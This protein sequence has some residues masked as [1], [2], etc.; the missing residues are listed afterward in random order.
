MFWWDRAADLLT[1]KGSRLKRFGLITTNSLKQEFSGRV[2]GQR[3]KAK[4]PISLLMAIPDHPWTKATRDAAAVRI[5]MTV[6][7]AGTHEG[8]LREVLKERDLDTDTPQIELVERR[9]P[10]NPDLTVG[11]DVT[12]AVALKANGHLCS[13][14]VKLHGSGFIV[15]REEAGLLG[16]GKRP[17]LERHIREYRNGRDLTGVSRGVMVIDLFGLSADEV[18]DRFPEVYQRV[19]ATVKPDRDNNNRAY[20]RE[21]WWLFGENNP[22]FRHCLEALGRYIATPETAKHRVFQFLPASILPDNMLRC[23]G[24]DDAFHLGVL[25]SRVHVVWALRA[26]GWLGVGNDPRYSTTRV[27]DPFRSRTLHPRSATPF[28]QSPK[29]S[30]RTGRPAKR[31]THVSPSRVCTTSLKSS[32]LGSRSAKPTSASTPKD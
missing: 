27:F 21:N 18:R 4:R 9:G 1:R 28:A 20:R 16:L 26:G 19:L 11:V 2:M 10:I 15:T 22:Q 31:S 13:P 24:L 23:I 30:T 7:A 14:G 25:S 6:A 29:I 12:S 32:G 8:I 17:G 3:L 5:A